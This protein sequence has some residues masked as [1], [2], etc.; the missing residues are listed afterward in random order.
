[1]PA[2]ESLS[3]SCQ[4][5]RLKS[6]LAG[7]IVAS[8]VIHLAGSQ[9]LRAQESSA[10][11]RS[12]SSVGDRRLKPLKDLDGYFP[13]EVPA[14]AAEWEKRAQFL[15]DRVR[16]AT[17][18]YLTEPPL[19]PL[20][21]VL[22]GKVERQGFTVERVYFES[23]PGHFVSGLLFRPATELPSDQKRPAVLSPHGHGGRMYD[24]GEDQMPKLIASGAEKFE[25]SGRY[26]KIARCVQLARMGCVAFIFDMLG[27]EDSQ[28]ISRQ[29]AHGF[30]KQ[31]KWEDSA[32]WG[33]FSPQAEQRLQSVM[34]IQTW[35][36]IRSLDF[37][38]SLPDVDPNRIAVT[39]GSGGGTQTILLGALDD[40]PVASFPNGMVSTAM[41]GGCTCEN[42]SMLRIGTGNVELAALFAPKPQA[43]TAANDWTV[44][45]MTKGYPELQKLYAMLGVPDDVYCREMLQFPHNYNYVSRET[46]YEWFN[47]HLNLEQENWDEV[48]FAPL[49]EDEYRVW[50]AEHPAPDGGQAYELRLTKQLAEIS[51]KRISALLP[52]DQAE[53]DHYRESVGGAFKL[54]VGR[55]MPERS[56]IKRAKGE[57]QE[58]EGHLFYDELISLPSLEESIPIYTLFPKNW[59][60]KV[61]IWTGDRGRETLFELKDPAT[62]EEKSNRQIAE[63]A[64]QL[65][66]RGVAVITA[67]LMGQ[68]EKQLPGL[69]SNLQRRVQNPREAACFTFCYNDSLL[70]QQVHDILALI[71]YARDPEHG[72]PDVLLIGSGETAAAAALARLVARG[73]VSVAAFETNGFRFA[74]IDHYLDR[75]ILPG[76]IKYGDMPAIL[77][78]SAPLPLQII[79]ELA[80]PEL[81]QQVYSA[82]G[83]AGKVLSVDKLDVEQLLE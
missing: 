55:A 75:R 46:M 38:E 22:H 48:D 47:R 29:L 23:I 61:A 43:M 77:A 57:E 74:Q 6:R 14:S 34:G 82:A 16:L 76:S 71:S 83:A 65:L 33:L 26:P 10:A 53:F 39:G 8:L 36:A 63:A 72:M 70:V 25:R 64:V 51:D 45:M 69:E 60:G 42:C 2:F 11:E 80:V 62:A 44:D 37:L 5:F 79:G 32:D 9:S 4:G 68:G 21:A 78:L 41:Q 49:T 31:R 52:T 17:G 81:T 7:L 54:I 24:Y 40:R 18:L 27:Y 35:N 15:K 66:R 12:V 1:M 58:L 67:D 19:T 56:A 50:N 13:F 3:G 73:R 20:N 59:A 30:S 28:Q